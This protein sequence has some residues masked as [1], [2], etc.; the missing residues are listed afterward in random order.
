MPTFKQFT[1]LEM[2]KSYAEYESTLVKDEINLIKSVHGGK[3]KYYVESEPVFLRNWET[4]LGT[5]KSGRYIKLNK[6]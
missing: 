3:T 2:A 4:L 6:Q 1:N 5:Y